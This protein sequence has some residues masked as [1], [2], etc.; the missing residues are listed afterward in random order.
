MTLFNLTQQYNFAKSFIF[1]KSPL[2]VQFYITARCNLACEQCNIIYSDAKH[3]EMNID[4]INKVAENLKKIGVNIVLLIGGE[5]FIRKDID[6]I[7]K[8]FTSR[9]IHV[10]MQ[11]NGI[12]TEKQ[13]KSCV[14]YGGKDISIS[15]DTLEPSLQ[16]EINGGFKK[17]W[18]RAINTI[19]NVSNIFPEN[20]TAFF[21]SVIMP[22]NLNQIIKVIKFATK[23]G[24]GVSLVPVHVS[25]PDHT[26]GYRTLDYDNNV[27]FDKSNESEIKELIIKL[28]EIKKDYNLYDSDEYLD[29]VEK[30]LLNKPVDWRKKNNDI[31]DSPN[32][33]FAISPSGTLKTCCDYE[34]TKNIFVYGDDFP[35]LYHSGKIQEIVYPITKS[36]NGCMYGSYPE[37]TITARYVKAFF[38][39]IKYFNY[40]PPKIKKLSNEQLQLIALETLNEQ[41]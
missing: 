27:T 15:L 30:F 25:T 33:Y 36:C 22:K 20:S 5:P 39:R 29:D 3:Q 16:D 10:R 12:A 23:I 1:K 19:S 14:N 34:A 18:T 35:D 8:A 28:K 2:Y 21:N 32:L 41:D 37:I 26:M 4:Q 31:C 7:V 13:L 24:W 9:N 6:K 11:T 40:K 17:S 38:E